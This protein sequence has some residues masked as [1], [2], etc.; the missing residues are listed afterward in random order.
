MFMSYTSKKVAIFWDIVPCS[1]YM[2]QCFGGTTLTMEVI[3][4]SETLVHIWTTQRYIQEDG[5]L[6]NYHYENFKSY[7]SVL[8]RIEVYDYGNSVTHFCEEL[9]QEL[10]VLITRS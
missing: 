10:T 3:Y 1:P 9:N 2:N 8:L 4:S 7:T 5:T 6:Y